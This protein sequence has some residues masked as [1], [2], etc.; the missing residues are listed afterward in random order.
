MVSPDVTM[1]TLTTLWLVM[2]SLVLIGIGSGI[3][4][5]PNA[6]AVMGSVEN[7]FLGVASGAI[8]T[9]RGTGIVLGMGITLLLFHVFIGNAQITADYYPAFLMSMKVGYII[10]TVICILAIL[11]QLAGRKTSK[12]H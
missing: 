3:F 10:F 5:A 8:G 9:L 12:T 11:V 6:K 7:R 4:S 2:T 1:P